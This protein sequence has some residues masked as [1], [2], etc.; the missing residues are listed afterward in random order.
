MSD[1][2]RW[3]KWFACGSEL[4]AHKTNALAL[5]AWIAARAASD[6]TGIEFDERAWLSL[7]QQTGLTADQ[8]REA[9]DTLIAHGL[10]TTVGQQMPA[11]LLAR[12]VL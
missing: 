11:R 8:G 7:T 10:V 12:A 1:F 5:M 3:S 2:A 9:L 4:G 6:G